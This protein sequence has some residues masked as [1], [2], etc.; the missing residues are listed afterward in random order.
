MTWIITGLWPASPYVISIYC[1][2]LRPPTAQ[3][4]L[5]YTRPVWPHHRHPYAPGHQ[6][7]TPT[8]N[9]LQESLTLPIVVGSPLYGG[10]IWLL[11]Q[12]PQKPDHSDPW[13]VHVI[14]LWRQ[15]NCI[16]KHHGSTNIPSTLIQPW[17]C[18]FFRH[19]ILRVWHRRIH[20]T[21]CPWHTVHP[22]PQSTSSP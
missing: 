16:G 13:S 21:F 2:K 7:G 19:L 15:I 22:P 1:L 9:D 14:I 5:V 11:L 6:P 12:Q 18:F 10:L 4:N 20:P 8:H 17:F 3:H